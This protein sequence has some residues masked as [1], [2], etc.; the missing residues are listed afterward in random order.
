MMPRSFADSESGE[1]GVHARLHGLDGVSEA[2]RSALISP[3]ESV[4]LAP[5]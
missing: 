3:A 2:D 4:R 1:R 5:A